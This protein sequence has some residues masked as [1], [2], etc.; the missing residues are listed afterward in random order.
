ME[1]SISILGSTGSIGRQTLD[2]LAGLPIRV[3]ALAAN[4]SAARMEE[5]CR[6]KHTRLA[7]LADEAAAAGVGAC[8]RRRRSTV[9]L[10]SRR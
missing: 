7:V 3:A 6:R 5:Q 9:T 8:W 2:V 10:S 1:Q 4:P